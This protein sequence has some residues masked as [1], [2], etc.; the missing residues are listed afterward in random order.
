M[1]G[2]R[3]GKR[4]VFKHMVKAKETVDALP[5]T[6]NRDTSV[7]SSET[8]LLEISTLTRW[9]GRITYVLEGCQ[10]LSEEDRRH[11]EYTV[12]AELSGLDSVFRL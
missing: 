3:S 10:Q 12:Q 9:S 1:F 11:L 8:L 2:A 4:E 5:V 7:G 6:L